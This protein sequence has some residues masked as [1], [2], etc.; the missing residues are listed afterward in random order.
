MVNASLANVAN[1]HL[2]ASNIITTAVKDN[3]MTVAELTRH[4]VED[5][6]GD[7]LWL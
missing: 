6:G 1:S 4:F 2:N 7:W 3:D 5:I